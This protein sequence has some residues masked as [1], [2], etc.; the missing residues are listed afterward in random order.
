MIVLPCPPS[1]NDLYGRS[2]FGIYKKKSHKDYTALVHAEL[3]K[4][5]IK[6]SDKP[7]C[8]SIA[9]YR[10]KKVGDTDN[11]CKVV[12]DS[13]AQPTQKVGKLRVAISPYGL[14]LNDNQVD[15][16]HVYKLLDRDNPRIE[17]TYFE[18]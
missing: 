14:Y 2:K 8:L 17:I 4:L 11:I 12:L 3:T 15:E 9:W 5:K 7:I 10:K 18:I 16:L 1:V 13:L 6:P